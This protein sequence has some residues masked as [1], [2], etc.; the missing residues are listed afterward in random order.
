MMLV[1]LFANDNDFL[2]SEDHE[3]LLTYSKIHY[4]EVFWLYQVTD[5]QIKYQTSKTG[6]LQFSRQ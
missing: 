6:Q 1:T 4:N 5:C 3:S 2:A